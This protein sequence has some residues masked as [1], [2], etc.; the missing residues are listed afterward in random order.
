MFGVRDAG[1]SKPRVS[2]R[3]PLA[4]SSAPQTAGRQSWRRSRRRRGCCRARDETPRGPCT[5]RSLDGRWE[6]RGSSGG[7]RGCEKRCPAASRRLPRYR[8]YVPRTR[9]PR[10]P[11]LGVQVAVLGVLV[12]GQRLGQTKVGLQRHNRWGNEFHASGSQVSSKGGCCGDAATNR[13]QLHISTNAGFAFGC[14]TARS[15][16]NPQS[17][18]PT[19]SSCTPCWRTSLTAP[20]SNTICIWS[21]YCPPLSI[22]LPGLRSRWMMGLGFLQGQQEHQVAWRLLA[23]REASHNA[24]DAVMSALPQHRQAAAPASHGPPVV[25]VCQATCCIQRN[26]HR[27]PHGEHLQAAV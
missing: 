19:Q 15:T 8:H 17:R 1:V 4:S 25:Q 22:R 23:G 7:E 5:G 3:V 18:R 6:C 9:L 27:S 21:W 10:E 12:D 16:P 13:W 2:G 26:L 14:T 24:D 11:E 20:V